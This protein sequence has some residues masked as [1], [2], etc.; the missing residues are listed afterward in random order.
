[1]H[2]YAPLCSCNPGFGPQLQREKGKKKKKKNVVCMLPRFLSEV[3]WPA[4]LKGLP[5]HGNIRTKVIL[6]HFHWNSI[7]RIHQH[8]TF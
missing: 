4:P 6:K 5:L 1:M 8:H 7:N 2:T 3:T